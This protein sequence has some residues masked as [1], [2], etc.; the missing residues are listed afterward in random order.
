MDKNKE[1]KKALRYQTV[2]INASKQSKRT[3]IP[4]IHPITKFSDVL[5]SIDKN[6]AAFIPCLLGK[7]KK[8]CDVFKTNSTYK[9]IV[10]FIGPEGDFTPQEIE[11][12]LS[13]GC[14]T[15]SLGDTVL[16]VDTAA[17]SVIAF[18][19]FLS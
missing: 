9:K 3:I 2:A 17:I 12:A 13:A 11:S 15:V 6:V 16:K 5:K 4:I 1:K 19:N 14:I 18:A 10:F 8:L 7:R